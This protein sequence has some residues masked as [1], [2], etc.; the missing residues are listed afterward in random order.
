MQQRISLYAL[1]FRTKTQY[2]LPGKTHEA[3]AGGFNLLFS[4]RC[5]SKIMLFAPYAGIILPSIGKQQ[6]KAKKSFSFIFSAGFNG[7]PVVR[8]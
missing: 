5:W 2:E 8:D 1:I 7:S 4:T 6:L 3:E